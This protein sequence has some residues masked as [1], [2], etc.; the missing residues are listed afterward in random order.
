VR[1]RSGPM[2]RAALALAVLPFAL[3]VFGTPLRKSMKSWCLPSPAWAQLLVGYTGWVV[4]GIGAGSTARRAMRRP[5]TAHWFS[6]EGH[7]CPRCLTA[8]SFAVMALESAN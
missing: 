7:T 5:E 4:R 2:H 8:C 6:A 1:K 3:D